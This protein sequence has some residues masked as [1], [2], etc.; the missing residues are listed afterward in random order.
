MEL[1]LTPWRAFV[2]V[3]PCAGENKSIRTFL[4][5]ALVGTF[6]FV[7]LAAEKSK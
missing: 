3:E 7:M 6:G 2:A 4:S 5:V 1:V